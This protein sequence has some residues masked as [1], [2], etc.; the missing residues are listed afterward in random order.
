[1]A[2]VTYKC[3]NCD[4]GLVF[5]PESQKFQCEY[6]LSSFAEEELKK[7]GKAAEEE[8]MVLYTCPSCGAEIVADETTAATFCYYCHNPVVL[9]GRLEGEFKP[10]KVI[11]FAI[12]KEQ[13]V[14]GFLKW[15]GKKKFIPNAFFAKAQIEKISGVYFPY[16]IADADIETDLSAHATK[17]RMWRTGDVEYTET[18]H[19]QV[20]RE[21]NVTFKGILRRALRKQTGDWVEAIHPFDLNAAK[22]FNEA[23]LLGFQAEKRNIEKA[24]LEPEIRQESEQNARNMIRSSVTEYT[25]VRPNSLTANVKQMKWY[26]TLLPVWI[27]TYRNRG[28][29]VYYYAMNGQTGAVNGALPLDNKKIGILFACIT[30]A[31]GLFTLLG[32]LV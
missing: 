13:A 27:V 15:T 11:P 26:Y 32:G 5:D 6:C 23:Y 3:P 1:M 4:G 7:A 29:K 20:Q 2:V 21:G 10:D 14:E 31:A 16:W 19:Y 17:I 30:L 18:R 25:T 9:S 8:K 28:D 12:S 24:E 22:P